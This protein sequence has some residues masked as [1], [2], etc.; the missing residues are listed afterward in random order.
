[1]NGMMNITDPS[2]Q[3]KTSIDLPEDEVQLWRVDLEAVGADE[4]RWQKLLS[5]DES[6]RA[7][8]FH[9][10]R[11]R[12]RFATSRAWLRIIAAGYLAVDP[13][14]LHFSYSDKEKPS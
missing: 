8:R 6:K 11:D 10:A 5:P 12:R 7:S 2:F 13:K 4:S 9:F 14:N 1:M 3:I